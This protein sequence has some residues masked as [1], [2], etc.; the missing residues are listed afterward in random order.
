[1]LFSKRK[2]SPFPEQS[3]T[4]LF[5]SQP[6]ANI[7]V[8]QNDQWQAMEVGKKF[9]VIYPDQKGLSYYW[10][11][12]RLIF[13]IVMGALLLGFLLYTYHRLAKEK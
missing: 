6:Q 9:R 5:A 3:L 1:L 13:F 10:T 12:Y 7:A 11:R 4:E 2:I 8:M